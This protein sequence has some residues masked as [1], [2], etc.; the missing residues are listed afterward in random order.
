MNGPVYV[1]VP[2]FWNTAVIDSKLAVLSVRTKCHPTTPA[3]SLVVVVEVLAGSQLLL[4]EMVLVAVSGV[5]LAETL[6]RESTP[7][8]PTLAP[9]TVRLR[10]RFLITRH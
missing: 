3:Q 6:V 7:H 2:A 4:Q 9:A 5:G 1:T 8:I 10:P